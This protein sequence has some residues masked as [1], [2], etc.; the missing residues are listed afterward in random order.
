MIG[1]AVENFYSH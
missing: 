1:W